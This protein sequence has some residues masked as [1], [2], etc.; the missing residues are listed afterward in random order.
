M[1]ANDLL[2][3][4]TSVKTLA[5][6]T[7]FEGIFSDGPLRGSNVT[8]PGVAGAVHMPKVRDAFVFS[9][10]LVILGSWATV[11]TTLDSLR[12][13]LNSAT[14]PLAMTRVREVVGGGG[15][16]TQTASG[17]YLD[18]LEPGLVGMDAGR[19]VVNLVNLSGAWT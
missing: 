6:I 9:V 4:G 11:N 5:K 18:G 1:T 12:A 7:S 8:Y 2:I 3:A 19:V 17:D 15:T 10:P 16:S 13:L 14:S